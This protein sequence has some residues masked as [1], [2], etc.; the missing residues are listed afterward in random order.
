MAKNTA[1]SEL[2]LLMEVMAEDAGSPDPEAE[3]LEGLVTEAVTQEPSGNVYQGVTFNAPSVVNSTPVETAPTEDYET[4]SAEERADFDV[5]ATGGY[6]KITINGGATLNREKKFKGA[7]TGYLVDVA[8]TYRLQWN[9]PSNPLHTRKIEDELTA[10]GLDIGF[11][12][13]PYSV[14][15]ANWRVPLDPSEIASLT[16]IE[17]LFKEAAKICDRFEFSLKPYITVLLNVTSLD[18]GDEHCA[19]ILGQVVEI[20]IPITSAALFKAAWAGVVRRG[21]VPLNVR[22]LQAGV[23]PAVKFSFKT[24]AT[25]LNTAGQDY[26]LWTI[27]TNV[28]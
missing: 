16:E 17:N 3:L 7:I 23:E 4:L 27:T 9:E 21:K 13:S 6:P 2:E 18:V 14:R 19:E 24:G 12:T 15:R 22:A 5:D 8:E 20:Q 25:R 26:V 28:R 1:N 11:Y 10:A